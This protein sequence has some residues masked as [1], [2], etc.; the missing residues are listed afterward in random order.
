MQHAV[1]QL[2]Q[3]KRSRS[4]IGKK[5]ALTSLESL[6]DEASLEAAKI[7]LDTCPAFILFL[8]WVLTAHVRVRVVSPTSGVLPGAFVVKAQ[9]ATN[10]G[11][12]PS[13]VVPNSI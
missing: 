12:K 2:I 8:A 5:G 13:S 9:P 4:R 6:Q 7:S 1:V 3:D 11:R 10:D